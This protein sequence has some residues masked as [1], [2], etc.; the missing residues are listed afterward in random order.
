MHVREVCSIPIGMESR[1]PGSGDRAR[2]LRAAVD[3]FQEDE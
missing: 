2:G 3:V 1:S